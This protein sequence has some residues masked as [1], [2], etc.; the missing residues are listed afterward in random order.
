MRNLRDAFAEVRAGCDS[1]RE[2]RLRILLVRGGLPEPVVNAI[3]SLAGQR[4]RFG[5]LVY[6]E[7]KVIVEYDGVHHFSP[8]QR[9]SDILRLEQLR[10]DGWIIVIVIA[11]HLENPAL[12]VSRVA[13]ALRSRGWSE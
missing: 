9:A 6:R 2:T 1:P 11:A 4:L 5:D 7:W 13:A 12:I 10:A 8:A 3:V